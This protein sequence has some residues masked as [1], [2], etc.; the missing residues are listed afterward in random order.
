MRFSSARD[1]RRAGIGM[2]HQEFTLVDALSVAEN[3][4]LSVC[5]ESR[6]QW[7]Q[8]DV[9]AA[10]ARMAGDL[11]LELGDLD[12]PV[13]TLPVG[14]RQ[15]VEIVKALAGQARILILD[16][17]TAVLTS[18]EVAQLFAVLDRLRRAGT[19]VLFITHKLAEVTAIADRI[20]VMRRGGI[21]GRTTRAHLT[22]AELAVLMVGSFEAD[23]PPPAPP[24]Q[25]HAQLELN[26]VSA[27]DDRGLTALEDMT[28]AVRAGEI[29]GI[30]G[31]DGNG[32]AELF[33][34]L[35]GLRQPASGSIAVG[36]AQLARF[37]PAAMSAAGIA[38]IPPD[39]QRQGIIGDMTV[40][41]NAL[42]SAALLRQVSRG[43]F[44]RPEAE[45]HFA[46]AMVEQYGI[47][48]AGLDAPARSLSGGNVQKL[49][50]ARALALTPRVLVA[51]NPTRGLD[52]AA[53]HAVYA[54]FGAALR[55]GAAVLLIST[56]LE[57]ILARAHRVS[58]L[59][60]GRPS[61]VLEPPFPTARIGALMA[62]SRESP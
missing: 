22:E 36:G 33:E 46:A 56:D 9:V 24:A 58:V 45:H 13:G 4:V 14:Q 52:I 50:V 51:V 23:A 3:L 48:V 49:V 35:S 57:E 12:R 17:P 25:A 21:V 10:A 62:G 59:Y 39:R 55:R 16:E 34:I 28:V 26:H 43:T 2:V 5:P 61:A 40:R 30:A 11:G 27:V 6:W 41:E 7:R 8:A 20:T 29:F 44:T 53:S 15:R 1:A 42:L 19:A 60:R 32:Q 54:A 31:V 18:A 38:C 47:R 37:E